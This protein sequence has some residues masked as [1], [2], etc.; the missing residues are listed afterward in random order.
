MTGVWGIWVSVCGWV[1]M[2]RWEREID[3]GLRMWV[4]GPTYS[5]RSQE[6]CRISDN[7]AKNPKMQSRKSR[8]IRGKEQERKHTISLLC[9]KFQIIL[10]LKICINRKTFNSYH[11]LH[12]T[13]KTKILW[14]R[15]P[16]LSPPR[17]FDNPFSS[18]IS[19]VHERQNRQYRHYTVFY[20]N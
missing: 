10:T 20:K 17:E 5:N 14:R 3:E 7:L 2:I 6:S 19:S 8:P 1:L 11:K 16:F 13:T 4:L 12:D 15:I 18:L 9:T